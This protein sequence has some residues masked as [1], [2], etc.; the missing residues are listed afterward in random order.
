MMEYEY[1]ITKVM[2]YTHTHTQTHTQRAAILML[3]HP[4]F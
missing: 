2:Q 3:S 4:G 1:K